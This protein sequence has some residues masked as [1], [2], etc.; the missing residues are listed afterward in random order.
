MAEKIRILISSE[1]NRELYIAI[2]ERLMRATREHPE[3]WETVIGRPGVI[4]HVGHQTKTFSRVVWSREYDGGPLFR[5]TIRDDHPVY[6][7][8]RA[9]IAAEITEQAPRESAEKIVNRVLALENLGSWEERLKAAVYLARDSR[10][11]VTASPEERAQEVLNEVLYWDPED[12]E[13]Q[14]RDLI[15]MAIKLERGEL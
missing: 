5:L 15:T 4:D 8:L 6:D 12:P 1:E 13:G 3:N 11:R 7:D 14:A 9:L 2:T 10:F